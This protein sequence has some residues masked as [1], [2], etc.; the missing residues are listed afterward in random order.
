DFYD[1]YPTPG[2]WGLAIGDVCGEGPD[3]PA[4]T[5]AARHA[6][7]ALAHLDADPEA[8]LRGINDIMLTEDFGRRFVTPEVG[9]LSLRGRA[10]HPLAVQRR[11]S[12]P[13]AGPAGWPDTGAGRGRASARDLPRRRAVHPGTRPRPARPAVP[14]YRRAYQR[15]RAGHGPVRRAAQR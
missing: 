2:G 13:G 12:R 1:V 6:I 4:V 9:P 7:R 10:V 3:T 8:V 14:A 15:V 11:P 5:A